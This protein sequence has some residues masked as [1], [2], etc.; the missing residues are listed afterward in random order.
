VLFIDIDHFRYFNDHYGHESGDIALQ[1][2]AQALASSVKRPL[3][4]V[5]R[6]GG[7]EFV[8]VLPKTNRHAATKVADNILDSVRQIELECTNGDRPRLTVSIGHVTS[9]LEVTAVEEDLVD[10][11]D[12]A[13]LQAKGQGRNQRVEYSLKA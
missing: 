6:W 5:C 1:A 9:T 10:E 8:V 13:M 3:D 12:K 4:F 2:V 7:E 11:A